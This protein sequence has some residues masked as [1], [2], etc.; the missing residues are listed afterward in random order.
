MLYPVTCRQN[1]PQI[2]LHQYIDNGQ[3]NTMNYRLPYWGYRTN[4]L[5]WCSC[6]KT[7]TCSCT[8]WDGPGS[9]VGKKTGNKMLKTS[10][11]NH[12]LVP[13][14][15]INSTIRINC[16]DDDHQD[17]VLYWGLVSCYINLWRHCHP[18]LP[19][20]RTF[21]QTMFHILITLLRRD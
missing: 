2:P 4:A 10:T 18:C 16:T 21:L 3:L 7:I 20:T 14:L 5:F 1:I 9:N 17:G 19:Q 13:L 8:Q 11:H 15:N 12:T 6:A